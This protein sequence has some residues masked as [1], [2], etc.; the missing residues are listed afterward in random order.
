MDFRPGRP[1]SPF[2]RRRTDHKLPALAVIRWRNADGTEASGHPLPRTH[3]EALLRAF[4]AQFPVPQFWLEV[5]THLTDGPSD[6]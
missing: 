4:Q 5:P 1:S 6:R 3:A 2:R